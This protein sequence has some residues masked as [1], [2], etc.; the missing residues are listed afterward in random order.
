MNISRKHVVHGADVPN[1]TMYSDST[2]LILIF[3]IHVIAVNAKSIMKRILAAFC[4]KLCSK[5]RSIAYVFMTL[6][7]VKMINWMSEH[8]YM[9][10]ISSVCGSL[11]HDVKM[12][13]IGHVVKFVVHIERRN[14]VSQ[15][16]MI[17]WPTLQNG[18]S[19]R[20]TTNMQHS[21]GHIM[22]LD[23]ILILSIIICALLAAVQKPA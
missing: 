10:Q 1:V 15:K 9:F 3:A 19:Q 21:F 13:I 7:R 4:K 18:F 23:S 16:K 22:R 5:S 14:G 8:D 17:A 2:M 20:L 12:A 11:A 6:K